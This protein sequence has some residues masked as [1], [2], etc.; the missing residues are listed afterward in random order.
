MTNCICANSNTN[1][2]NCY[3]VQNFQTQL[4]AIPEGLK[5]L[6]YGIYPNSSNYNDLRLNYNKL[7][8]YFP[9]AIFYPTTENEISYLIK[10]FFSNKLKFAIRCGGHAYW[11]SSLSNNYILDVSKLQKKF[12]LSKS[13]SRI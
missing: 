7:L 9:M 1:T 3:L 2:C 4:D 11:Q 8:N 5:N 6:Y 10:Q 13:F 12:Y